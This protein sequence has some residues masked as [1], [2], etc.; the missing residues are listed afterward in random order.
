MT[1]R[2]LD[3]VK[4]CRLQ[5]GAMYKRTRQHHGDQNHWSLARGANGAASLQNLKDWLTNLVPQAKQ[6]LIHHSEECGMGIGN[7]TQNV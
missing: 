3:F 7:L 1:G 2:K 5:F 4:H 6:I